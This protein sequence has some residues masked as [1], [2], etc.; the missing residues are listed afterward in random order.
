MIAIEK[1]NT[2]RAAASCFFM[3][4]G[5]LSLLVGSCQSGAHR[6]RWASAQFNDTDFTAPFMR[7]QANGK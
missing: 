2:L 7:E 6:S 1:R 3:K 4:H 5:F